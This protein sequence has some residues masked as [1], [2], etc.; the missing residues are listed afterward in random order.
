[1][2]ATGMEGINILNLLNDGVGKKRTIVTSLS[3]FCIQRSHGEGFRNINYGK[4]L[5]ADSQVMCLR[6]D[7]EGTFVR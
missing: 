3:L 2:K 4:V 7:S 6:L 5:A 1:M